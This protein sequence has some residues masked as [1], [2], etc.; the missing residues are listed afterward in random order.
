VILG[1]AEILRLI[2]AEPPL[3]EGYLD[4]EAQLQPA[5]FELS[6]RE[7]RAFTTPGRLDFT[8]ARR[9]VSE[10]VT[11][12]FSDGELHLA[13]GAYLVVFNEKVNIPLDLV[14]IAKPRS[15]L[16][17][18]GV[19]VETAV[20][21]PGYSGRSRALMLVLNDRGF[22]VERNARLVQ[23]IFLRV[24]GDVERGYSGVYQGEA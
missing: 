20:W 12:P 17:R 8:N 15:S 14:A 5:G 3:I 4:L 7:V 16:L 22:T 11:L 23:L 1:R 21:D 18:S 13:P 24:G 19:T 10:T 9:V 2:K 6:L